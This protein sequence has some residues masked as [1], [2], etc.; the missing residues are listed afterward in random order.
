MNT[1]TGA[2]RTQ[3]RTRQIYKPPSNKAIL[4]QLSNPASWFWR[5]QATDAHDLLI[6]RLSKDQANAWHALWIASG[7]AARSWI[8][9]HGQI[10]DALEAAVKL[11]P[12]DPNYVLELAHAAGILTLEA[13]KE[14]AAA[15]LDKWTRLA[16]NPNMYPEPIE[17]ARKAKDRAYEIV[18]EIALAT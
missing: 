13:A 17:K 4:D 14:A 12:R 5:E 10:T 6:T 16:S 15:A 3:P 7:P 2:P 8:D 11:D 18:A 9:Q 1:A